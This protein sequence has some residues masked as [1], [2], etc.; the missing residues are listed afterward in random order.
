LTV[1]RWLSEMNISELFEQ[2]DVGNCNCLFK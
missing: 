1:W 2:I